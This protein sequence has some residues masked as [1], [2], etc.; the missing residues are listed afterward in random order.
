M[1]AH[2]NMK[3]HTFQGSL[4]ALFRLMAALACAWHPA[5]VRAALNEGTISITRVEG[6]S[7]TVDFT[8]VSTWK[9]GTSYQPQFQRSLGTEW[10][11]LPDARVEEVEGRRG[12]FRVSAPRFGGGSGFYRM[13][14][15]V[16]RPD[17]PAPN[18]LDE[19]DGE[20]IM[21]LWT[22]PGGAN[23]LKGK[24]YHHVAA[25]AGGP[26]ASTFE[27]NPT[28]DFSTNAAGASI[29][30]NHTGTYDVL[31]SD[32][33]GDGR[34]DPLTVWVA[35]DGT[36]W[37]SIS[38]VTANL[39]FQTRAAIPL[40]TAGKVRNEGGKPNLIRVLRAG[41]PGATHPRIWLAFIAPNGSI[42]YSL[43]EVRLNSHELVQVFAGDLTP[44]VASGGLNDR[45]GRFDIASGDFDGDGTDELAL[46]S[47]ENAAIDGGANNWRLNVRFVDPLAN[48][49]FHR[50]DS[51][52][53]A[54]RSLY[55]KDGRSSIWLERVAGH[56]ADFDGDGRDELAVVFETGDNSS[57]ARWYLQ[58][59]K[60]DS[61]FNAAV[62][63]PEQAGQIDQ[64]NGNI[65]Y[66]LDLQTGE[67][68]GDSLPELIIGWR[69]IRVYNVRSDLAYSALASSSGFSP[70]EDLADRRFIT[71]AN[72]DRSD[73]NYGFRPEVV[74][75]TDQP[76]NGSPQRRFV[77]QSFAVTGDDSTFYDMKEDARIQDEASNDGQRF[78]AISAADFG[79][80]GP[81]LG[82]PRRYTRVVTGKP[83]VIVNA[84]PVHFDVI[85]GAAH[86]VNNMF[87][88]IDCINTPMPCPFYSRY[89]VANTTSI[90]VQTD[91][92]RGW[93]VG[94][95]MKG[96]MELP[97]DVGLKAEIQA[98]FGQRFDSFASTNVTTKVEVQ[99]D[100]VADDR[101][102]ASTIQY[103]V[104]E[105]PVLADGEIITYILAYAPDVTRQN[106]FGS[107]S[108]IA[109]NYRHYHEYGNLLSYRSA[110][111]PYPGA[112]YVRAIDG[113]D[114][115]TVD[116]SSAYV[117]RLTRTAT[118]ATSESR[119]FNFSIQAK[120]SFDIPLP[121]IPDVTVSGGYDTTSFA[122]NTTKLTDQQG[123]TAT[124][125]SLDGGIAGTAYSITP[126]FY[127]DRSGAL[128]LDYA[129]DLPAG[130]AG[131]PTFWGR[132]YA[133]KP[134]PAFVLPW[135][136]DPE[137]GLAVLDETQRQLTRE[138]A[139]VPHEPRPGDEV[140][141]IARISNF[142]LLPTTA[143]LLAR[144]YF[145]D[146]AKGGQM[147]VSREGKDHV[148]IPAGL[149]AR[150]KRMVHFPW[151]I[152]DSATSSSIL[153]YCVID[154]DNQLDEI[155]EDNNVG[156]NE[157]VV[158]NQP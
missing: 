118:T 142:S 48:P 95:K 125:G 151:R 110:K 38:S 92:E 76:L 140:D 105:Y 149:P 119:S 80:N 55:L 90:E 40:D 122:A 115:F 68:D 116:S 75:V 64:S 141:L 42:R 39:A 97:L 156:W 4:P 6:G 53:P 45:S 133:A 148:L 66:P 58:F 129:V 3:L 132:H 65:G 127:W 86:D 73:P 150:G 61:A 84:P 103:T 16:S 74:A 102:Y 128:V 60:P 138:I 29:A 120:A 12:E 62:K 145:G 121:W 24:V 111:E 67:F 18:T 136:L 112:D 139:T 82:T 46:L 114:T 26:A 35:N 9:A 126:Y 59:L 47:T 98:K 79:K 81:K 72:L 101:V 23:T 31:T 117:W 104:W 85:G 32:L 107:K 134:D 123:L 1:Q 77:V 135:R 41:F 10:L 113:A 146:P 49:P 131:Q 17:D 33:D 44:A 25:P 91:W 69:Q 2:E 108:I 100:A 50:L 89:T 154:A 36:I 13:L 158:R 30:V 15:S 93:N 87:P 19:P 109:Q 70:D 37:F 5:A 43:I 130:T 28:W 7:N 96:G 94:A 124:L 83:V 88:T 14:N 144:F 71:L 155:H 8:V 27:P 56:A 54:S 11:D 22:Q 99:I 51:I 20:E 143:S 106:W 34:V 63:T 152:P 147:L 78:A 153:I 52:A 57:L 137:K 157:I 21:L